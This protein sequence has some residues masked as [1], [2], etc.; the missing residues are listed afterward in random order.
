V[1]GLCRD[2]GD[3]GVQHA[4]VGHCQVLGRRRGCVGGN[5]L[6]RVMLEING[7]GFGSGSGARF[8]LGFGDDLSRGIDGWGREF[9]VG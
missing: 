1:Q 8:G 3:E 2:R 5:D 9:E 6:G 4:G 7:L